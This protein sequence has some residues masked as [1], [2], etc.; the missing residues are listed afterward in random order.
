MSCRQQ[1]LWSHGQDEGGC[2]WGHGQES[3]VYGVIE[4]K[5]SQEVMGVQDH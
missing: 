4:G 1:A 2:M 5:G 3:Y